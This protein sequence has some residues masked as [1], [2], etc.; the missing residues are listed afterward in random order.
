V[1]GTT[2]REKRQRVN[3]R[4]SA[5]HSHARAISNSPWLGVDSKSRPIQ[6]KAGLRDLRDEQS[7]QQ[8]NGQ[9]RGDPETIV[10]LQDRIDAL[11]TWRQWANGHQL[12]QNHIKEMNARLFVANDTIPEYLAL[13]TTLFHD[14]ATAAIVRRV[15]R[16]IERSR[17]PELSID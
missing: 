10:I 13:R 9:W 12:T 7:R 11:D 4:F 14:A 1:D 15:D 17:G 16:G 8:M 6:A 3:E 5:K 2:T